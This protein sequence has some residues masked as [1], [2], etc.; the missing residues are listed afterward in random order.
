MTHRLALLAALLAPLTSLAADDAPAGPSTGASADDHPRVRAPDLKYL[1][2]K[3]KDKP[4]VVIGVH[5]GKF[6]EEKDAQHIRNAVL[7]HNISHPVAVDSDYAIWNH[8]GVRSWPSLV[9]I[10][11]EGYVVGGLSGEGHR[12]TLDT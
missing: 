12:E 9:L 3:Y 1:E 5:S 4:L 2:D 10:D 11:P 7:R 6:D 8:Y